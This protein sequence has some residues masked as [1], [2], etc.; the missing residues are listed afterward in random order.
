MFVQ[1]WDAGLDE[2]AWQSWIAEGH[3]FGQLSVNGLS[4]AAT[5]TPVAGFQAGWLRSKGAVR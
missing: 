5:T 3:D 2:A 1:P 4:S